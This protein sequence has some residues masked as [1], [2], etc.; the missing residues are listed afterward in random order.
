MNKNDINLISE[1]YNKVGLAQE[2]FNYM[3]FAR[4]VLHAAEEFM[5]DGVR[6]TFAEVWHGGEGEDYE[7][8]LARY[9]D[10]LKDLIVLA[11]NLKKGDLEKAKRNYL[12]L[13]MIVK[14][15]FSRSLRDLLSQPPVETPEESEK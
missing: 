2:S 6:H 5:S 15:H 9:V 10:S 13:D 11:N 7:M 14:D 12:G 1:A 8:T 4:E 3:D